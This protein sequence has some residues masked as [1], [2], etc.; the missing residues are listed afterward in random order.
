MGGDQALI[1]NVSSQ[2]LGHFGGILENVH[3][4]LF[5][6]F[7]HWVP[8]KESFTIPMYILYILYSVVF[9]DRSAWIDEYLIRVC[10]RVISFLN[11]LELSWG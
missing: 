3:A 7:K 1:V 8:Q 9:P 11:G 10:Y 5:S 2:F 4:Q 6:H